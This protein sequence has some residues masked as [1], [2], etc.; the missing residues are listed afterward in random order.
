MP[1]PLACRVTNKNYLLY[2][3]V[4]LLNTFSLFQATITVSSIAFANKSARHIRSA[5]CICSCFYGRKGVNA[6]ALHSP[7]DKRLTQE[8]K[9]GRRNF[10]CNFTGVCETCA[11]ISRELTFR[12]IQHLYQPLRPWSRSTITSCSA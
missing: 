4:F 12:A 11:I 3:R 10:L 9:T 6:I 7:W 2:L 8:N 5:I 1:S